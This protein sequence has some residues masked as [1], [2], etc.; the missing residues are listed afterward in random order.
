MFSFF[1]SIILL[2]SFIGWGCLLAK[3]LNVQM[4]GFGIRAVFG[5]SF[6][7]ALGGF[8]NLL[9]IINK[10]S[11]TYVVI[12]GFLLFI[13][14][15][16]FVQR[17]ELKQK[18][19]KHFNN[20]K[21]NKA[22][23]V[24]IL[25]IL[26][27]LLSRFSMSISS[28]DFNKYDD[29]LA[30]A[31]FPTKMIQTGHLGEDPFSE[32]RMVTSLGGKYF[33]DALVL[34]RLSWNNLLIVDYGISFLILILVV[35]EVMLFYQISI[36]WILVF[37]SSLI[38]L[39]SPAGNLTSSFT[40]MAIFL[41]LLILFTENEI[42]KVKYFVKS[43]LFAL[44]FSA[45]FVLKSNFIPILLLLF[46]A[47]F[48]KKYLNVDKNIQDFW[49]IAR[50]F[51]L[52]LIF[53]IIFILPWM[54]SL[55]YSSGT[56][57]YP[58]LGG[59]YHGSVYGD[60]PVAYS[61]WS[62]YNILP[63]IYGLITN[64]N[65]Y[66]FFLLILLVI[67]LRYLIDNNNKKNLLFIIIVGTLGICFN[68]FLTGG[69]GISRYTMAFIVP[70]NIILVVSLLQIINKNSSINFKI[71]YGKLFIL[72]ILGILI[73][74]NLKSAQLEIKSNF[75][76]LNYSISG[77]TFINNNIISEYIKLQNSIPKQ[78][79]ILARVDY[80]FLFDYNRNNIYIT[81]YIGGS[82]LPPGIP[83]NN[84][85][86]SLI[87]Y[88]ISNKIRY[89]AFSYKSQLGLSKEST[90]YYINGSNWRGYNIWLKKEV[91]NTLEFQKNLNKLG[92]TNKKIY[93]DGN[94]Y[95]LDLTIN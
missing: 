32:T 23:S 49:L 12:I 70:I 41:V 24:L 84:G 50:E 15:T 81:D 40:S 79:N 60:L 47:Y 95:I 66:I 14:F 74:N 59:G 6:N 91:E 51:L 18:L 86:E 45:L 92:L 4:P 29:F 25:C 88:L 61:Q 26:I 36:Y 44:L 78:E 46:A 39:E 43:I 64:I 72:L 19:I 35:V 38:L 1:W 30:Y 94:N 8:F 42:I 57:L 54:I 28:Q 27:I 53:S 62:G 87:G 2:T 22:V 68:V 9:K 3:I 80:P 73:G 55:F 90:D 21:K 71:A 77:Q 11:L 69:Y 37:L 75:L 89:I 34:S 52:T 83:I 82:S 13:F 20:F 56:L 58:L 17:N 5:I 93:D 31:S 48:L 10:T 33:L 76:K 85:T 65:F 63:I 16:I 67:Y 7:V